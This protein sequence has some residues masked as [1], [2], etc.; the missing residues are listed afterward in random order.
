[1]PNST[2]ARLFGLSL[3]SVKRNATIAHRGMSL[4]PR[5]GGGRPPKADETTT[6]KLLEEDIKEERPPATTVYE[7]W[8][9]LQSPTGRSMSLSTVKRLLR[10]KGFSQKMNCGGDGTRRVAESCLEAYGLGEVGGPPASGFRGREMGANTY[11]FCF[12]CLIAS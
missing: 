5:K 9:F 2:A 12:A 8:R 6:R 10:R 11:R 1:M 3:S 4:A 7:R